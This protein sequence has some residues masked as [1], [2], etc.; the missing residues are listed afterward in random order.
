MDDTEIE[1]Y[2]DVVIKV[3]VTD[4]L[5]IRFSH[6]LLSSFLLITAPKLWAAL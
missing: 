4:E 1:K 5:L 3:P 2:V 6:L